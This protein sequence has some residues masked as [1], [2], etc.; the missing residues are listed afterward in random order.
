M[1]GWVPDMDK[2]PLSRLVAVI[3]NCISIVM[4]PVLWK[5]KFQL[6][7]YSK[8]VSKQSSFSEC[9]VYACIYRDLL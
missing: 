7:Q 6:F 1:S 8:Y 3:M 5:P 2:W 9:G 4:V